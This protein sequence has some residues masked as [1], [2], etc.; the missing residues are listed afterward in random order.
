MDRARNIQYEHS[1]RVRGLAC[2]GIGA[3]HRLAQQTGL[4][5]ALDAHVE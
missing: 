3:M 2:G 1:D 5:T 4:V